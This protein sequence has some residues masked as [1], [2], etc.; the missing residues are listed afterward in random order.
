MPELSKLLSISHERQKSLALIVACLI[1]LRS[2]IP[3]SL[4]GFWTPYAANLTE[5][6]LA[7]ARQELY[8]EGP[9]GSVTLLVPFRRRISKVG[10]R[11]FAEDAIS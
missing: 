4:P 3:T 8:S 7:Q 1:I 9:D 6:E 11:S 10:A 5:K 2:H